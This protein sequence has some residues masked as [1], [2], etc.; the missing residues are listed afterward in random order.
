MR[1]GKLRSG[2][3]QAVPAKDQF[4]ALGSIGMLVLPGC[5]QYGGIGQRAR[6]RLHIPKNEGLRHLRPFF[7]FLQG[8]LKALLTH[9][10]GHQK[11]DGNGDAEDHPEK[12]FPHGRFPPAQR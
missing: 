7:F 9:V 12:S 2:Q 4:H 3:R 10:P 1:I 5:V 6:G 11:K 8:L